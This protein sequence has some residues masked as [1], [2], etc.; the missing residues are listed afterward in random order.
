M[1]REILY[2]VLL[3]LLIL[4]APIYL[5]YLGIDKSIVFITGCV[6]LMF[7]LNRYNP[8]N[9]LKPKY[10]VLVR[11][12]EPNGEPA[13]DAV[14]RCTLGVEGERRDDGWLF[15]IAQR[16][17]PVNYQAVF[18]TYR[19]GKGQCAEAAYTFGLND[20]PEIELNLIDVAMMAQPSERISETA[21]R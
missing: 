9:Y 13:D 5:E 4:T 16:N 1:K 20:A 21:Q 11:V 12:F 2:R 8:L 3:I 15:V 10:R 19:Q 14:V 18:H 17:I 6:L 7:F